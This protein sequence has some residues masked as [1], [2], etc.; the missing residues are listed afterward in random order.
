MGFGRAVHELRRRRSHARVD[1]AA[2]AGEAGITL[3][4]LLVAVAIMSIAFVALLSAMG[5]AIIVSDIHRRQSTAESLLGS[6]AETLKA[7][8]YVSNPSTNQTTGEYSYKVV[9]GADP[10]KTFTPTFVVKCWD[11]TTSNASDASGFVALGGGCGTGLEQVKLDIS[12][13]RGVHKG[14]FILKRSS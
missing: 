8:S 12:T 11:G 2:R 7:K 1:D 9:I 6:W 5:T 13:T 14:T 3:V 4:E 10:P